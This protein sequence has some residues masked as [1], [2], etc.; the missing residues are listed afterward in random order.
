MM[1]HIPQSVLVD[2]FE[3]ECMIMIKKMNGVVH[4]FSE[5]ARV[6][7][8][9]RVMCVHWVRVQYLLINQHFF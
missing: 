3:E 4:C 1:M 6:R 5:K 8:R 9:V 7:V 2:S